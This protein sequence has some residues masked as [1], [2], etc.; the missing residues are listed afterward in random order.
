[1]VKIV[2]LTVKNYWCG[3]GWFLMVFANNKTQKN[4]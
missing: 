2:G 4:N 3:R 1:M